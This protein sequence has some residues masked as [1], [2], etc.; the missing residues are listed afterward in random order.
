M[1]ISHPYGPTPGRSR[2]GYF[3][4]KKQAGSKSLHT[5]T[6]HLPRLLVASRIKANPTIAAYP[7]TPA[8]PSRFA[9]PPPPISHPPPPIAHRTTADMNM[10]GVTSVLK[11]VSRVH[12]FPGNICSTSRHRR[13][14]LYPSTRCC[15]S[16][17]LAAVQPPSSPGAFLPRRVM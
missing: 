3:K 9:A 6:V 13:R 4:E 12:P 16:P 11:V 10:P 15:G 14:W 5:A 7:E 2:P 17:P 8:L 1:Y